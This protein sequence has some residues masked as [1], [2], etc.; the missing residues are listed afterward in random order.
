MADA[1]V[2]SLVEI[3]PAHL[4]KEMER[5]LINGW[6]MRESIARAEAKQIAHFG[7]TH[8]AHDVQG[9]GRKIAEIPADAYH[10]WGQRLGYECWK[11]KQFMREFLRD[12]PELAVRN[13]CK[14]TVV[15]GTVFTADG[16]QV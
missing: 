14:K 7:H 2:Q 3:I 8:E 11:D 16:Y 9:L 10:Y 6:R 5:E 12:N 15:Q 13:Y 4:H 1:F